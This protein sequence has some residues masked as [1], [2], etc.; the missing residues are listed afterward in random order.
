MIIRMNNSY[1]QES[2]KTEN[3]K[4]RENVLR[5]LALSQLNKKGPKASKLQ[6]LEAHKRLVDKSNERILAKIEELKLRR[7][8]EAVREQESLLN[9]QNQ[10]L[11]AI[12]KLK[13][14][15]LRYI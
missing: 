6:L 13:N 15:R 2:G 7:E 3:S 4:K 1:L 11:Q 10:A 9:E 14:Q 8:N 12:R 5:L